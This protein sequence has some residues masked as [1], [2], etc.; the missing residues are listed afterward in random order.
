MAFE[1]GIGFRVVNTLSA[2]PV[3]KDYIRV[4]QTD[5]LAVKNY[6]NVRE[7]VSGEKDYINVLV[8][9]DDTPKNYMLVNYI[10]SANIYINPEL[11][12]GTDIVDGVGT[13][14]TDHIISNS[15][16]NITA[17]IIGENPTYDINA[18]FETGRLA[19]RETRGTT[20]DLIDGHKYRLGAEVWID[21]YV[22]GVNNPQELRGINVN[23]NAA[24]VI[25]RD[26]A[27]LSGVNQRWEYVE[28][29]FE[30]IAP[31]TTIYMAHGHGVIV[32]SSLR[33]QTRNLTLTDLG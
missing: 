7:S 29:I 31:T 4:K 13:P 2:E 3:V 9:D 10:D 18:A 23:N 25:N 16:N 6:I 28:V 1:N 8:V 11:S 30:I 19:F 15:T 20:S 33:T 14:P 24:L 27:D 22:D 26:N 12:G 17:T 5:S 32:E 21:G